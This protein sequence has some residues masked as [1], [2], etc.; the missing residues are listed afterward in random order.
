M[1][2][3]RLFAAAREAAGTGRDEVPGDTVAAVLAAASSRYGAPFAHVLETCRI[4]VNGDEAAPDHT[5]GPTDEV[6]VLPPVSGGSD[7]GA[8]HEFD[9]VRTRRREL[10]EHDDA[11]SYVRRVAQ[12]RSDLARAEQRR[13][14]GAEAGDLEL[15]G[16]LADRLLGGDRRPPRPAE[17][18]SDDARAVALDELCA[19]RGFAR[20]NELGDDE[21]SA[22]VDALDDFESRVSADRREVH[23]ELDRLTD[24]LVESYRERY[25]GIGTDEPEGTPADAGPEPDPLAEGRDPAW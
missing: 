7:D 14:A 2:I 22:L 1:A 25:E 3:V 9:P 11:I 15:D 12:A 18:F 8:P 20:L 24:E 21:L 19:E 17:E 10:Q 16:V 6:A 13:R 5:V 23:A 4:W